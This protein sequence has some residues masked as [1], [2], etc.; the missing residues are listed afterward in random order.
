MQQTFPIGNEPKVIIAQIRGDL[1]VSVL[2][3]TDYCH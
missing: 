2:G 3:S 1:H